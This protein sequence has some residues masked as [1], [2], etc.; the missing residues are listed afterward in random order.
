MTNKL[1]CQITAIAVGTSVILFNPM[2]TI[3]S[4]NQKIGT[5]D[6]ELRNANITISQLIGDDPSN[7]AEPSNTI[8]VVAAVAVAV[9]VL[10]QA[11]SVVETRVI[12]E[13]IP[14]ELVPIVNQALGDAQ[15]NFASAQSNAEQGDFSATATAISTGI[16][17][18]G[19]GVVSAI[20]VGDAGTAQALTEVI[21]AADEA[22]GIAAAEA[23]SEN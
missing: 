7:D 13:E 23:G 16:R 6:S 10:G 20:G 4:N 15:R 8:D 18:L 11:V 12:R 21:I 2:S 17:I 3:A 14:E 22:Q 19:D 9:E 5:K 1:F